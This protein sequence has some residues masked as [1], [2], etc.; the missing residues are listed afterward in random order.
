MISKG[1]TIDRYLRLYFDW[2]WIRTKELKLKSNQRTDT[3]AFYILDEDG[4]IL[5]G[6][7]LEPLN[8][9]TQ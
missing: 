7:I 1:Y 9:N 8:T 5:H 6:W 4:N 2:N 3:H